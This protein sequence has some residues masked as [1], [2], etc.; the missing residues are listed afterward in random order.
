MTDVGTTV[1]PEVEE[2]TGRV[3]VAAAEGKAGQGS[4]DITTVFEKETEVSDGGGRVDVESQA[5]SANFNENLEGPSWWIGL[6][7]W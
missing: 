5:G 2:T 3:K 4:G 7:W 6:R 1:D